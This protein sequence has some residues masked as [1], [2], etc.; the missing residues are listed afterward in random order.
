MPVDTTYFDIPF[1]TAGNQTTIP[2]AVDP[3]GY[4]SFEQGYPIGYATPAGTPG[5]LPIEREKF[6]YLMYVVTSA[7]QQIQQTSYAPYFPYIS[8]NGGYA[9]FAEVIYGGVVYQSLINDN[10]DTPPSAN[11]TTIN[12]V[13]LGGTGL[14]ATTVSELLAGGT[15]TTGPLQQVAAVQPGYVLTD[16]GPGV[17][18]SFQEPGIA[19]LQT[20]TIIFGLSATAPSNF[21]TINSSS[22]I[23]NGGSGATYAN[24]TY[25]NIF[26]Y[27]WN[28]T[29]N[30]VCPVSSGRG[31]SAA[32]DFAAS[33][34]ITM[35]IVADRSP[36][37][38]GSLITSPGVL[39]GA[40]TVSSSGS[41]SI[42]V[43]NHTLT[44]SE[45]PVLTAQLYNSFVSN[46]STGVVSSDTSGPGY[47]P[48]TLTV[49]S[50]GGSP[51]NHTGSASYTGNGT[52]VT[53]Q[54]VGMYW[55]IAI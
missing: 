43:D 38:I 6:N 51:H 35:P 41:V 21:L 12:I 31:G 24:S 10:T 23:G 50:G 32:A 28:N 22:T 19:R 25:Q 2:D 37:G 5:Y 8:A 9:Q 34:T 26:E 20:G 33:K 36:Y 3:S 7:I 45:T 42:T 15:S 53:H 49:N 39:A 30:S 16:G 52:S 1:A 48:S 11:W 46:S 4:V 14:A 40:S 13:S 29:L 17:L 55:Y 47:T 18:P 54:V 44:A 27:L